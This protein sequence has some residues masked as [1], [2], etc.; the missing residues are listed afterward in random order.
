MATTK[1]TKRPE[2]EPI[3]AI[4]AG[5]P[6]WAWLNGTGTLAEVDAALVHEA[7][8]LR[9]LRAAETRFRATLEQDAAHDPDAA[10]LRD[11]LCRGDG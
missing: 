3:G 6:V 9:R 4:G 5:D 2:Q 8:R 10:A 11:L 1:R 7:K